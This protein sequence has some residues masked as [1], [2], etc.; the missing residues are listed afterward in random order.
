MSINSVHSVL[1]VET[2]QLLR[3]N[4]DFLMTDESK[5]GDTASSTTFLQEEG[6][7]CVMFLATFFNARCWQCQNDLEKGLFS[8]EKRGKIGNL[9]SA[10]EGVCMLLQ[11]YLRASASIFRLFR[12]LIPSVSRVCR[13]L[14]KYLQDSK[15]GIIRGS[16]KT[17]AMGL[18]IKKIPIWESLYN[19]N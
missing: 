17:V 19:N 11:R 16:T 3:K 15:Y 1:W 12:K 13:K 7:I 8:Q 2:Y 4:K 18:F 9:G 10:I 5:K 14:I 6:N